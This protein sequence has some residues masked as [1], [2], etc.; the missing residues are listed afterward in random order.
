MSNTTQMMIDLVDAA[1]LLRGEV[2]D[3]PTPLTR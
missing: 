1:L 3:Q 2:R